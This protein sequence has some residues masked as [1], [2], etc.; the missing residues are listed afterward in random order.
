MSIDTSVAKDVAGQCFYLASV[1]VVLSAL[2][3]AGFLM[4]YLDWSFLSCLTTGSILCA[5]DPVA[6][7]ALLKELGASPVLTIQIQGESLL[8]DGTAIVLY[9]VAYKMLQGEDYDSSDIIMFLIKVAFM[10]WALGMLIGFV[11]FCWIR[12]A[13]NKLQHGSEI[14]QITLTL[15]CGY[16]SF[17]IAEGVFHISGVL[18]CVAAALTLAHFMWPHV[19]CQTSMHHVWHML[20]TLGNT[21]IFFLA[22]A[23]TGKVMTE[24][25]AVD[26]L[27]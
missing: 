23:L 15:A 4:M 14:I 17:I 22:G 10:A 8:N 2:I 27:H 7:V 3:V 11:F 6:V 16:W 5:T 26:Y 9:S 20:E 25:A 1:G 19:C 18:A 21:I 24:I 13:N 12:A